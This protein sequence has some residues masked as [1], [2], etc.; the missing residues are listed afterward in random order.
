ML[1]SC[2]KCIQVSCPSRLYWT[3][4]HPPCSSIRSNHKK[5][6][7]SCVWVEAILKTLKVC[8]KSTS[9]LR[10]IP[11]TKLVTWTKRLQEPGPPGPA[12]CAGCRLD[13]V[14]GSDGLHVSSVVTCSWD[15]QHR[16]DCTLVQQA[17]RCHHFSVALLTA[18]HTRLRKKTG[19]GHVFT[20]WWT[21]SAD[22]CILTISCLCTF[23]CLGLV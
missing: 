20:V 3:K 6:K 13:G 17:V 23:L 7:E 19:S 9:L 1:W 15:L 22:I 10:E 12:W 8:I 18:T 16:D 4:Y 21:A 5:S 11:P 2:P 14:E